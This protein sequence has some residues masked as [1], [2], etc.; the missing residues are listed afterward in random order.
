VTALIGEGLVTLVEIAINGT[1]IRAGASEQ[2]FKAGAKLLR[3]EAAI[4]V[5]AS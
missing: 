4:A 5:Q 1:K 2:S 3:V